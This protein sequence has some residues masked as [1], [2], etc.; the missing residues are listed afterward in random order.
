LAPGCLN[1]AAV[2][3]GDEGFCPP[4]TV[5]TKK[6][7]P[8]VCVPERGCGNDEID[9]E[10]VCD[11]G[12]IEGGDGC[13]STCKSEEV[14]GNGIKD[15][16][17]EDDPEE[18]DAG[19]ETS[20]CDS[21][22]TFP[23]CGD[24]HINSEAG[25]VCDDGNTKPGD[26]CDAK[27]KSEECGNNKTET[28]FNEECDNGVHCEDKQECD[29]DADCEGIGDERCRP[30]SNDGCSADCQ[31]ELCGN[32][33]VDSGEKCDEEADSD[34]AN[35]HHDA[36]IVLSSTEC[37]EATCGDGYIWN[38]DCEGDDCETCDTEGESA[39]CNGDCTEARCGDGKRN[40]KAG[41]ACDDGENDTENCDS[42][43]TV[44]RCGDGH[45]NEAIGEA[46]DDGNVE[47]A[48]CNANCTA[49]V[50]GDEIINEAAGEQCDTGGPTAFCN[51]NCQRS[52][53]G[54]GVTDSEAGEDCDDG[55]E[56]ATCNE[57]CTT[58]MCGDG[59]VNS[60]FV[61]DP[62]ADAPAPATEQCDPDTGSDGGNPLRAAD[63]TPSCDRDCTYAR[64]GDGYWNDEANEECD[65]VYVASGP[66][67]PTNDC[68]SDCTEAACGDGK[69]NS[70]FNVDLFA[71]AGNQTGKSCDPDTGTTSNQRRAESDSPTCDA[72]CSAVRCGDAHTNEDAGEECDTTLV[73]SGPP[74][75]VAGCDSDCTEP[76]C[77]D[78]QV[79]GTFEV[80]LMVCPGASGNW[81]T[82][83]FFE[84]CDPGTGTTDDLQRAA[85][86]SS[87]CDEDCTSVRCGDGHVNDA[88]GED[89]EVGLYLPSQTLPNLEDC[90][91]NCTSRFCGDGWTNGAADEDCD[92]GTADNPVVSSNPDVA[93]D[94]SPTCD[95]DCT[96][97][98][99]ND[100]V[101]NDEANEECEDGN[102]SN[103]DGC[104]GCRNARCGDGFVRTGVEACDPDGPVD[105]D[106]C[107]F[108]CTAVEC[109]DGHTN[110]AAG[111][112]C[113]DDN[114][115]NGDGCDDDCQ[116]EG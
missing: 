69:L 61:V 64:C 32:G 62:F 17:L 99:C 108:D 68:N 7:D 3:C 39:A 45:T 73:D 28:A 83:D 93:T 51:E 100:G 103:S 43:C 14:C 58:A 104:V 5:C 13:D 71:P 85:G 29:E 78:G 107:D 48:N 36:C 16:H 40:Q 70:A 41:E 42:D 98:S 80:R 112:E 20:V 15:D 26:G 10:E 77:G 96:G 31:N 1:T 52:E 84:S 4:G 33:N 105:A 65:D 54:D 114:T 21:D 47:T 55:D 6:Q 86:P 38:E 115:T 76:A 89:C 82:L 57:N 109:G 9:A 116:V 88:A 102:G 67:T 92:P 22:C 79:N 101:V 87:F 34:A 30:R 44:P 53:C 11:D 91:A 46:C 25:E 8:P 37:F 59:V 2:T 27:C 94:D 56:S 72:D 75:A 113:D 74:P 35:N 90:N 49:P 19:E 66:K 81:C 12:N 95:R 110:E 60:S 111:E 106:D 97:V 50:C 18:C 63:S 23:E 24:K